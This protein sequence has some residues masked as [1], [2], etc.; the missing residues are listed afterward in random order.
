MMTQDILKKKNLSYEEACR[1]ASDDK[2]PT[3]LLLSAANQLRVEH[4][5]QQF[6]LCTIVN[7]KSGKCSE[8]CKFCAQSVHYETEVET[9]DLIDEN[10]MMAAAHEAETA[11]VHCFSIVTS[12]RELTESLL[13]QL[14]PLYRR[15]KA[16]TKLSLCASHGMLT[17]AQA[18]KLKALGVSTYH[19][20]LEASRG[21]YPAVCTTHDYEVRIDTIKY[22]QKAGLNVCSG[23]IIGIGEKMHDRIEMFMTLRELGIKSI[24]MNILM[25]VE[26]T[27]MALNVPVD[28]DEILRTLAMARLIL[29]DASIRI[30]GGRLKLGEDIGKALKGGINALMVGNYLTTVGNNITQDIEMLSGMGYKL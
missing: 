29:K 16:E 12:G 8:D 9:Y 25:P 19:H 10:Q 3:D 30:A 26:G 7:G 4:L 21:H 24:P 22:C 6:H 27:P 2:Y 23:G 28:N 1:L 14:T 20:N 11:G 15:L 18:V 5:E 13:A 17:Q